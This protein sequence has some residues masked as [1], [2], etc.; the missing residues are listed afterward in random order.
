MICT[1]LSAVWSTEPVG[2]S[3]SPADERK[4]S[5]SKS[6]PN[7]TC[8]IQSRLQPS[9]LLQSISTSPRNANHGTPPNMI[10]NG[11]KTKTSPKASKHSLPPSPSS[12]AYKKRKR[13]S[14]PDLKSP[15]ISVKNKIISPIRVAPTGG[16]GDSGAESSPKENGIPLQYRRDY[17]KHNNQSSRSHRHTHHHH[18][19]TSH[20]ETSTK[21]HHKGKEGKEGRSSSRHTGTHQSKGRRTEHLERHR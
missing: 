16:P 5:G 17:S 4:A 8:P 14:S 3:L 21:H 11:K 9:P 13:S 12:P 19:S 20:R 10:T 7:A 6:S 15:G 18:H 2:T 1:G